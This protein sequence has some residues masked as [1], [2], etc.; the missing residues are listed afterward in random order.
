[1]RELIFNPDRLTIPPSFSITP[2]ILQPSSSERNFAAWN[3]T[4]PALREFFRHPEDVKLAQLSGTLDG[5]KIIVQGLGN[6]G[7][8][9]AKFLSE[10]DGCRIIGVIEKDGGIVNL[11]GL[12]INSLKQHIITTGGVKDFPDGDFIPH[13]I[14]LLEHNCDILIPAAM[15][16]V[17][18]SS[19]ASRI[20]ASLIIEAANGPITSDAALIL[21]EKGVVVIPDMYA[22]AGGVV[23]S[24]F[25]WAKN[26]SHIRYGRL[27]KRQEEARNELIVTA[28]ETMIG[29]V[30]I[31][32]PCL[33][34]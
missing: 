31:R 14:K 3:P 34:P 9:A 30:I 33:L 4:F 26:L 21:Q 16:S 27:Q 28:L 8:H 23:V 2:I 13:G 19:N 32:F 11:S 10:E 25:E 20:N 15:E 24:Y 29:G 7:F 5:K 22:N 6:V 17:I 1:L 18:D 12:N